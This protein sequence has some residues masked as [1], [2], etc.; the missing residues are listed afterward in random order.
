MKRKRGG[1]EDMIPTRPIEHTLKTQAHEQIAQA[2]NQ[3][4]FGKTNRACFSALGQLFSRSVARPTHEKEHLNPWKKSPAAKPIQ[5]AARFDKRYIFLITFSI[6]PSDLQPYPATLPN[7]NMHDKGIVL[8]NE[9]VK[10]E[11]K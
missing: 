2:Q 6:S 7:F 11:A 3:K 5:I 10:V 4:R 8:F 9:R 1:V